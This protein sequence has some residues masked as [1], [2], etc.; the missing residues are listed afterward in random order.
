VKADGEVHGRAAQGYNGS[1]A[2]AD[3]L[4][5]KRVPFTQVLFLHEV[6]REGEPLLTDRVWE[7]LVKAFASQMKSV[8]TASSFVKEVFTHGC[9][10]LFPMVENLIERVLRDTDVK[11]VLPAI[12]PEGKGQMV[13]AVD[14]F[15]TAF[16]AQC[17]SRLSDYVNSVFPI[18]SRGCIPSKDQI[19]R[20]V[21]RVQEEIEVVKLHGHLMLLVLHRLGRF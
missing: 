19:S 4:S 10:K 11:G 12:S 20:I 16:L 3:G 8:F 9:P 17:L 13:A 15:Q 7:T 5:K 21:S 18:S 6:W 1:L 14:I 2:V